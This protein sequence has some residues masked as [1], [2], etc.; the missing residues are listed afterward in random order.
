MKSTISTLFLL[1]WANAT[2]AQAELQSVTP[3]LVAKLSEMAKVVTIA[4]EAKH[5]VSADRALVKLLV[6]TEGKSLN[7]A[8]EKNQ[9][10]RESLRAALVKQGIPDD[11]IKS[12][13]FSSTPERGRFSGK[14]KNYHVENQVVVTVDSEKQFQAIANQIDASPEF[15]YQSLQP[16]DSKEQANKAQALLLACEVANQKRTAVEQAM[17]VR[18]TPRKL[19][20]GATEIGSQPTR[21]ISGLE[22]MPA[23]TGPNKA[24]GFDWYSG[25]LTL[26][27]AEAGSGFGELTYRAQIIVEFQLVNE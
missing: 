9:S 14:V 16:V 17:K 19:A 18:L 3:A 12:S 27:R 20:E 2:F 13:K 10:Q 23:S 25:N 24:V 5:P 21:L 1:A 15:S 4:A 26:P 8:L 7:E 11:R 6:I 22:A